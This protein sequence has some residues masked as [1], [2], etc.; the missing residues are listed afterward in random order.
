MVVVMVVAVVVV[1]DY[2]WCQQQYW[3]DN[4]S[5]QLKLAI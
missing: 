4:Y 2:L 3:T 1:Q 5:V